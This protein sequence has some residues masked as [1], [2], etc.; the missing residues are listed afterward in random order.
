MKKISLYLL[1]ILTVFLI[2]WKTTDNLMKWGDGSLSDKTI[3]ADIGNGSTNP[4]MIFNSTTGKWTFTNDGV[5]VKDLGSGSG[6]GSGINVLANPGCENG[7]STPDNWTASGGSL[8]RTTSASAVLYET[9]SCAWDAS[10]SAQTLKTANAAVPNILEGRSC[11]AA[12]VYKADS[13]A[14]GD[15][16]LRAELDDGTDLTAE[17]SLT[18][19]SGSPKPAFVSF[20][21]PTDDSINLVLESKVANPPEIVVDQTHLGSNINEILAG[22]PSELVA[23]AYFASTA[24][25]EWTRTNTAL[26]AFPTDTDCPAITVDVSSPIASINAADTD[27]PQI[28]FTSLP[29]G[30]YSVMA[31]FTAEATQATTQGFALHDGTSYGGK[32]VN[33]PAA[34]GEYNAVSLTGTFVHTGGAKTFAIHCRAAALACKIRNADTE[35]RTTFIV[36]RINSGT[37]TSKVVLETQGWNIN[38]NIG[39]ANANL[40]TGSVATQTEINNTGLNMILNPGSANAQI[41]CTSTEIASGLTCSSGAEQIGVSFFPPYPGTYQVCAFLTHRYS[42][43][44]GGVVTTTWEW[45]QTANNS[46]TVLVNGGTAINSGN[47]SSLASLSNDLAVTVCGQFVLTSTS[48][49]TLRLFYVQGQSGTA[50]TTNQ[51]LMDRTTAG[52]GRSMTISVLPLTQNFP[53]AVAQGTGFV[54]TTV[55]GGAVQTQ[56]GIKPYYCGTAYTNGTPL[57]TG[58]SSW[59]TTE[60]QL[61]PYQLT[62]GV[63]RLKYFIYGTTSSTA[64]YTLTVPFTGRDTG[65]NG[66]F[67]VVGNDSS[68]GAT[69]ARIQDNSTTVVVDAAVAATGWHF[70][71]EIILASKPSWAD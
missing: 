26:G 6:S 30:T 17:L 24:S 56:M 3:E 46:Q 53:Q 59:V 43:G 54:P 25:C 58:T 13:I 12:I 4:K 63:W 47:N 22:D 9:A 67:V 62:D 20:F 27:L 32:V 37:S 60:C 70:G 31:Q 66:Q 69:R 57:I 29:A 16:T 39:G 55:S 8:T 68:N 48:R 34:V 19:T 21:C 44:T 1:G 38:A 71:G 61:I 45:V 35:S 64:S 50:P 15:Y 65:T 23:Q 40:S 18:P 7:T 41:S 51:V 14:S 36:T 52:T 2:A 33:S 10:A 49:Q 11:V 5:N 28:V 42:F